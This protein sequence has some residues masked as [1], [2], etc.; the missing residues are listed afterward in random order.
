[1]GKMA[2]GFRGPCKLPAAVS[3]PTLFAHIMCK[4]AHPVGFMMTIMQKLGDY[5]SPFGLMANVSST[6]HLLALQFPEDTKVQLKEL[7]CRVNF[8]L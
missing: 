8:V 2:H 1:M 7:V 3:E 4:V 5:D 6:P